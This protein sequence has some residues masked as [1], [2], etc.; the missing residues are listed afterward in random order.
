MFALHIVSGW[1][2]SF[3]PFSRAAGPGAG[4]PLHDPAGTPAPF[5]QLSNVTISRAALCGRGRPVVR[6]RADAV[7]PG[8][9]HDPPRRD[10]RFAVARG[11]HRVTVGPWRRCCS[12]CPRTTARPARRQTL[13]N[14]SAS[15]RSDVTAPPGPPLERALVDWSGHGRG[16][17]R[18]GYRHGRHQRGGSTSGPVMNSKG[19]ACAWSAWTGYWRWERRT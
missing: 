3:G 17:R 13:P 14:L 19:R 15:V 16:I 8:P 2:D 6:G 5:G 12:S 18:R 9:E 11:G 1:A 7:L 10:D 4:P